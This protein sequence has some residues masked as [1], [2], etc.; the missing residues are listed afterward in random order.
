MR[1]VLSGYKVIKILSEYEIII[2]YGLYDGAKVGQDVRIYTKGEE[3]LDPDTKESLG[4]LDLIKEELEIYRAYEGF[5]ICRKVTIKNSNPM[6]PLASNFFSTTK[7]YK[8]INI[9]NKDISSKDLPENSPVKI[10]DL[11]KIID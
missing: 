8:Q 2:N 4:T 5:S 3:I 10:G 1:H 7:E 6:S 11:V 9:S